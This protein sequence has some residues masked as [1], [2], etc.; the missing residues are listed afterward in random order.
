MRRSTSI[1]IAE[2]FAFYNKSNGRI[3]MHIRSLADQQATIGGRRFNFAAGE[4]THT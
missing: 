3:E 2:R 4:L 1:K